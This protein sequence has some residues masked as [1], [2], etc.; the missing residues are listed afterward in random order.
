MN[1]QVKTTNTTLTKE[2]FLMLVKKNNIRQVEKLVKE[3]SL[4]KNY[5]DEASP[6][7]CGYGHFTMVKLLHKFG[8]NLRYDNDRA[9][10]N[11]SR[12]GRTNVVKFLLETVGADPT[13]QD[14]YGFLYACKNG[15][16][17]VIKLFIEKDVDPNYNDH[18]S[19][20]V[21]AENGHAS[22]VELLLKNK[23]TWGD[24]EE[25]IV[26]YCCTNGSLDILKICKSYGMDCGPF[27]G[28]EDHHILA[29][30]NGY[31]DIVFFLID[32]GY[33]ANIN[34]DK[35]LDWACLHGNI[36]AIDKLESITSLDWK[37]RTGLALIWATKNNHFK[38][39]KRCIE[40]GIT[41]D[42]KKS[43][44]ITES[45]NNKNKKILEF[46]LN[47]AKEKTIHPAIWQN[48]VNS[49]LIENSEK[50]E[51]LVA[52]NENLE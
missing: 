42:T 43:R 34:D 12:F 22:T 1:S 10:G 23:A 6:L 37:N 38:V 13:A 31:F 7:A 26:I 8:A 29:A 39:V 18:M 41:P 19:I 24:Y 17:E 40:R 3:G 50:Y 4:P 32:E 46:L 5:L 25:S 21:S 36:E 2:D 11:A 44:P 45:L 35:I 47:N 48:V 30:S 52:P 33:N 15:H 49:G 14:H 51:N 20:T 9:L 27:L 28:E 16:N